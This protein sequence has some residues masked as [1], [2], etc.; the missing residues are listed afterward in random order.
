MEDGDVV[1]TCSAPGNKTTHI[2]AILLSHSSEPE[3]C[4]QKIHAFE[5]NKTRAKTLEKMVSIAGSDVWTT[6]HPG[7][8]FLKTSPG[9]PMF[10]D[11]GA[12]LLDPSCS[13]SGIV[14]RDDMPPLH[15]PVLEG[16]GAAASKTPKKGSKRPDKSK[17]TR[18]RKREE[19]EDLIMVDDD[20][21][22][23]SVDTGDE[24]KTRL[25]A[26]SA[27]QLDLLL[28]A[29]KFPAARKITYS[30]CSVHSEENESVVQ[31]ALASDI[32]KQHG[33]RILKRAD[34]VRGMREWPVR[35][36]AE[37]CGEED[38]ELAEECI[39]ANKGD[40][41]GTM[42]FFLAGFVR[43]PPAAGDA[44]AADA[45]FLRDERGHMVRD[46]LGFPVRV[47]DAA[48]KPAQKESGQGE[49]EQGASE[50]E[51][52]GFSDDE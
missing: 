30:T 33:W 2:A 14:G 25:A 52:N 39:R 13:G 18:K 26:L 16:S 31:L 1:D 44:D 37:A 22:V 10:K 9:S 42:G 15:L 24:L 45:Q 51:W 8:D 48:N 23:T 38:T 41:H 35:G 20:G 4:K 11:V 7:Q 32:A 12:L 40:E 19:D 34:Q 47:Q 46:V 49:D 21:V 3:D 17:E 43:D 5:K 50:E 27:F 28:H 6:L 29:F 36:S